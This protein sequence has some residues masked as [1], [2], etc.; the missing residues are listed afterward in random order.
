MI[1]N[2]NLTTHTFNEAVAAQIRSAILDSYFGEFDKLYPTLFRL[3][4]EEQ[5]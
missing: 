1:K 4:D 2:R 5:E 3:K